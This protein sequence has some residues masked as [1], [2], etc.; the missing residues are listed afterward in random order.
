MRYEAIIGVLAIGVLTTLALGDTTGD[1]A[2]PEGYREWNHV[3]SMVILEG[4][5]H[6]E[7]FGGFHH[8]YANDEGLASLKK[9]EAFETGS[10]LVFELHE[11]VMADHS[12]TEG[13][14]LVIGVMEKAPDRFAATEGWGFED[15]RVTDEGWERSVTDARR[16]CLSCHEK[17]REND[18]VYSMYRK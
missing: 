1:V 6:F 18:Y 9:E 10:V 8:V 2:F 11:A 13:P 7:A 15:F 5:E 12:I 17:Q 3:K 4:H 14:R 16:Q